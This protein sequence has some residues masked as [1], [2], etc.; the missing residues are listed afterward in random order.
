MQPPI[1]TNESQRLEALRRYNALDT[2]PEGDF[3]E[4]VFLA[5]QVCGAPIA[6]I[7]LIDSG[8]Q[9][10]KAKLGL[11]VSETSREAA[12]CAHAILQRDL[13]VVPD[14]LQDTRFVDNP[15]VTQ[16]PNIRFYAGAPLITPDG[17]ALGTLCVL[18]HV[19]RELSAQQA[20]ALRSLAHEVVTQL[21]VRKAKT[22]FAGLR[23]RAP[24]RSKPCVLAKS[25]PND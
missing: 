20:R 15:L 16:A 11:S 18:D 19:P 25:S 12:F 17:F 22:G 9:W 7:S 6:L 10:F 13:M 5:A 2:P 21:E 3:D 24:V 14:A 8:R 23:A 4:L 1:P